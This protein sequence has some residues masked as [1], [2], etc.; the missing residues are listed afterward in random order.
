[1][2]SLSA[3]AQ[4]LAR[5]S[6]LVILLGVFYVFFLSVIT[7]PRVTGCLKMK[8]SIP[9][10]GFESDILVSVQGVTHYFEKRYT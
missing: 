8:K 7:S 10:Q 9:I 2:C 6:M 4:G 5:G 1:M 3:R